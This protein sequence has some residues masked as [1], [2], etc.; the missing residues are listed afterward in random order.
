MANDVDQCGSAKIA[1]IDVFGSRFPGLSVPEQLAAQKCRQDRVS[2]PRP[3]TQR[4][5]GAD[6]LAGARG[7][8]GRANLRQ[9]VSLLLASA[10]GWAALIRRGALASITG[11]RW[12]EE[13]VALNVRLRVFQQRYRA[14]MS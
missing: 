3:H 10:H 11:Q 13:C 9:A 6:P 5:R 12:L 14:H 7:R 4:Q 1:A 8:R 2:G